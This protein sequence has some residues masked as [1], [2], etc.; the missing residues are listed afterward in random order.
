MRKPTMTDTYEMTGPATR[1][2]EN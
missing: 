2:P 1:C